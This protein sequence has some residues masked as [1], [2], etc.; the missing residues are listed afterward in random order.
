MSGRQL[1]MKRKNIWKLVFMAAGI[2][3]S[4]AFYVSEGEG[5]ISAGA[6]ETPVLFEEPEKQETAASDIVQESAPDTDE[7]AAGREKE[8]EAPL[9]R[10]ELEKL[11]RTAVR[12]ELMD[13]CR[14]GYL[15]QALE[16]AAEASRAEAEARKGMVDLNSAGKEE[17]MTLEGIGEKRAGDIIAYREQHGGFRSIEE[18][19]QV[20]GIKESSYAKIADKIYVGDPG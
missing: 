7:D 5:R 14:D 15:E 11:V 13:I 20:S 8:T 12:E 10:E 18:I 3:I 4:A 19:K 1:L 17:L 2:A 16:E 9:S 6:G